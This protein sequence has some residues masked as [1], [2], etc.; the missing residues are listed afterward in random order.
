MKIIV[1]KIKI[2]QLT[3]NAERNL[4]IRLP[5]DYDREEQS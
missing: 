4:Y 2:P 1:D 5:E 3:G